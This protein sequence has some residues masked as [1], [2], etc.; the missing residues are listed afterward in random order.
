M[1]TVA[2]RSQAISIFCW[3]CFLWC[4][5]M[6]GCL[7]GLPDQGDVK[8]VQVLNVYVQHLYK[9]HSDLSD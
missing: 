4:Q 3:L 9:C 7:S 8:N 1:L 6:R 5:E 2:H